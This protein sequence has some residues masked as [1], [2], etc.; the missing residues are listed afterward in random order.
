[1]KKK[2]IILDYGLGNYESLKAAFSNLNC[3]INISNLKSE[4]KKSDLIILPGVGT[5]PEAIKNLKKLRLDK[6]LKKLSTRGKKILGICLG[7]QLLTY[8]SDELVFTE[9]LKIIKGKF[10]C[11]KKHNIGWSKL[12]NNIS[13]K[14]C[15]TNVSDIIKDKYFYHVHSYYSDIKDK[16]SIL[17]FSFN[18]K[19]KFPSAICYKNIYG[20]QFHP[21]KSGINGQNLLM[22]IL[23]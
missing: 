19:F 22:N 14:Y 4:L 15:S 16:N 8:S 10:K 12:D 2:V 7:M 23:N 1:M 11:M 20:F 13:N 3:D 17:S 18:N 6:F 21:E 5:F 9:G